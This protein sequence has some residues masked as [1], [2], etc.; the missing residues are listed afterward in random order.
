MKKEKLKNFAKETDLTK[1]Q[2]VK[3]V[4]GYRQSKKKNTWVQKKR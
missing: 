4:W 3:K 2:K 1:V